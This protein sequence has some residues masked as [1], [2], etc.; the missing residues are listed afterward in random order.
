MRRS[1]YGAPKWSFV[2]PS[3]GTEA[4]FRR[5]NV[6]LIVILI[7]LVLGVFVAAKAPEPDRNASPPTEVLP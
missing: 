3:P 5:W 7:F 4:R 6:A 2:S 1:R